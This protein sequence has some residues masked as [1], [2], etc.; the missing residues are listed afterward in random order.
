[1]PGPR[2]AASGREICG[3][4]GL[5]DWNPDFRKI[6]MEGL[7]LLDQRPGRSPGRGAQAR[8]GRRR[9]GE[10]LP[11]RRRGGART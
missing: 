5:M 7:V 2:L 11:H 3:V 8:E 4:G 10:D 1:M 9:V 6:G